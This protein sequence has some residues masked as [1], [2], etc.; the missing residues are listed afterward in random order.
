MTR[1][2]LL[3]AMLAALGACAAPEPP[4]PTVPSDPDPDPE[5][6][7]TPGPIPW[8]NL[9]EEHKRR[10]RQ[11]LTRLGED[12]PDEETLQARWMTM[13]PAQQRYMIRRPPPPPP[14][15]AARSP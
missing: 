3:L 8:A 11:A 12:I 14:R 5:T 6:V 10:A 15:P 9:T 7:Y 2:A 1:R 13:S 4:T